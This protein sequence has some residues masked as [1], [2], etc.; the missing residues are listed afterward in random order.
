MNNVQTVFLFFGDNIILIQD[1][2]RLLCIAWWTINSTLSLAE[3]RL[4]FK[5][6]LVW[7]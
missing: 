6:M 3:L 7:R 4:E 1:L 5:V 2:L